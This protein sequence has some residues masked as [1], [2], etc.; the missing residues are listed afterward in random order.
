MKSRL[1]SVSL[2]F[3]MI[4]MVFSGLFY[5]GSRRE[6]VQDIKLGQIVAVNE[7]EQLALQ[8]ELE[9]VSEKSAALQDSLRSS[10]RGIAAGREA[11]AA[12]GVG[13]REYEL[14]EI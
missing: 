8:G 14:V 7:L 9:R 1:I 6:D 10:A 3:S 2:F 5:M 4:I 13:S 11:A 12:L